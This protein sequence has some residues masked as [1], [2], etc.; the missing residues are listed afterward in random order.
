MSARNGDCKPGFV[1]SIVDG[2]STGCILV[3]LGVGAS[4]LAAG[5]GVI[6]KTLQNAGGTII[7]AGHDLY[8]KIPKEGKKLSR[9]ASTGSIKKREFYDEYDEYVLG[10][11][12]RCYADQCPS[13]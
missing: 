7:E 6:G 3:G 2:V 4:G 9:K 1:N 5:N 11:Y 12:S 10:F 8:A 13:V